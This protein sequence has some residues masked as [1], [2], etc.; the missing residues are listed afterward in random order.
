MVVELDH[1]RCCDLLTHKLTNLQQ[2]E[3]KMGSSCNQLALLLLLY[4]TPFT[5]GKQSSWASSHQDSQ[6]ASFF[7][8]AKS[9]SLQCCLRYQRLAC[10][11]AHQDCHHLPAIPGEEYLHD[12]FLVR[13]RFLSPATNSSAVATSHDGKP[14][15]GLVA[16]LIRVCTQSAFKCGGTPRLVMGA[17]N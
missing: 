7:S 15:F 10:C 4:S 12:N 1:F 13:V 8:L 16:V 2:R 3:R 14:T 11:Q 17:T 5:L 9:F 6:K